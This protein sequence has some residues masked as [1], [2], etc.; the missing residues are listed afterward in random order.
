MTKHDPHKDRPAPEHVDAEFLRAAFPASGAF[1]MGF[2]LPGGPTETDFKAR[3][4][5]RAKVD[6][7]PVLESTG[8]GSMK[9]YFD[10][11]FSYRGD[12]HEALE[13]VRLMAKAVGLLD[14][15]TKVT[16]SFMAT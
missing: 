15:S 14:R 9:E 12:A 1:M 4:L 13:R 7:D 11:S 10:L 8:S 3:E 2:E 5:L 6:A 16:L